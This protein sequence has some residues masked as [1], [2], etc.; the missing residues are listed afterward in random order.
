MGGDE[1][2]GGTAC[3]GDAVI[4]ERICQTFRASLPD[5]LA[6]VQGALWEG[7][8]PRLREARPQCIHQLRGR[9][10]ILVDAPCTASGVVRRHP[11][12]KWL[13]RKSDVASFGRQPRIEVCA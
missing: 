10:R 11:D 7:D 5:H 4:L 9:H 2:G 3:G 6:A 8:A 1:L 13:R 12:I